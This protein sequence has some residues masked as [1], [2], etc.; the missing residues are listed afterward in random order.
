[1]PTNNCF[2]YFFET[3]NVVQST[4]ALVHKVNLFHQQLIFVKYQKAKLVIQKEK[5]Y[6]IY[7]LQSSLK[8]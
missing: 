2:L 7:A 3:K 8:L 6:G 5:I 4:N 1:V